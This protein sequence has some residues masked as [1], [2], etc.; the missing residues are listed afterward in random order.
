M[1]KYQR[2]VPEFSCLLDL[3][4]S[5]SSKLSNDHMELRGGEMDR[6]VEAI[7]GKTIARV[8]GDDPDTVRL[9]LQP[10]RP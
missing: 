6:A 9:L 2:A 10:Y 7:I 4:A 8:V 1:G 5:A 3:T